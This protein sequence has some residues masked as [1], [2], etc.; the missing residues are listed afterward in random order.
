MA[1]AFFG[2]EFAPNIST[3]ALEIVGECDDETHGISMGEW[4]ANFVAEFNLGDQKI[5]FKILEKVGFSSRR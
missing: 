3:P 1:A 2:L 4:N 5:E